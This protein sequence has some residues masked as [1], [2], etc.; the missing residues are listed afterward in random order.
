[1]ALWTDNT[2]FKHVGRSGLQYRSDFSCACHVDVAKRLVREF[3][4]AH[5][6]VF[7]GEDESHALVF[8]RGREALSRFSAL[9][10]L[11]ER[12]PRQTIRV[13]FSGQPP[14]LAMAVSYDV[15]LFYSIVIAPSPLVKEA[16][17]LRKLLEAQTTTP[18]TSPEPTV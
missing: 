6:A 8:T 2:K 17:E 12:W 1:M 9:L 11:S 16:L 5:G 14:C 18:I 3:Y 4:Q 13:S 15:R 10:I 7:S